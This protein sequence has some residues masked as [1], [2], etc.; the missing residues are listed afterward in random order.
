MLTRL[1]SKYQFKGDLTFIIK[2]G[3]IS[4]NSFVRKKR[5]IFYMFQISCKNPGLKYEMCQNKFIGQLLNAGV[6]VSSRS[7][8]TLNFFLL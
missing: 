8:T 3:I 6:F 1:V 7:P 2:K 4:F 5:F